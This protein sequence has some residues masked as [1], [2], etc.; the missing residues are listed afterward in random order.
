MYKREAAP[1]GFLKETT[2]SKKQHLQRSN[3]F[4]EAGPSGFLKEATPL[5]EAAP[6][7]FLKEAFPKEATP[8]G[9]LKEAIRLQRTKM[10]SMYCQLQSN[11]DATT[12]P[13]H[14]QQKQSTP[15]TTLTT[16]AS[17]VHQKHSH[18]SRDQTTRQNGW[19]SR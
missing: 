7:E 5:K 8:S 1:S 19:E 2:P 12:A 16:P 14:Q 13:N 10:Q 3:T 4:K 6:S 17:N 11:Q 15:E 9:L 18:C